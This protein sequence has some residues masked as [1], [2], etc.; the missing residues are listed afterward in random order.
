MAAET[1]EDDYLS[2]APDGSEFGLETGGPDVDTEQAKEVPVS[3]AVRQAVRRLHEN[4][5]HRSPQRLARALLIAGAPPE[6]VIAAKQLKCAVCEE[7]RPPKARRPASLPGPREPGD[8][9][10]L[11]IF[12]VFD[13]VG[14]RFAVLHAVDAVTKF[15]MATLVE[16]KSTAEVVK[17]LKERWAPVFGMPRVLVSDQGRE[18][19]SI[20]LEAFAEES[21]IFLYRIGVQAPWQNGLCERT[22]GILK[23]LLSACTAAKSLMGKEEMSLGLG[24]SVT[25]YNMDVGDSGF[26]PM[27][28]AVGRQPLLPG[29][30]LR[31]NLA[32]NDSLEQP[33]YARLVAIRETTRMAMLRLHFSR[34][35]RR[36]EQ[37]RSRNPTIAAAPVVGD[38]V[39]YWREQKYNKRG[40]YNQ[41]RLLLRKWHGSALLVAF[42]GANCYVTSRG[43]LTK[44]A[45]EHVRPASAMEKLSTGEWESVLQEVVEAAERDQ[46]WEMVGPRLS[47]AAPEHG[48]DGPGLSEQPSLP[49]P[50]RGQPGDS[51]APGSS[52][53]EQAEPEQGD[54]SFSD[55]AGLSE[56]PSLPEPPRGPVLDNAVP[57]QRT[58][59]ETMARMREQRGQDL[60]PVSA[61][62]F[63][64]AASAS[65]PAASR[66][67]SVISEGSHRGLGVLPATSLSLSSGAEAAGA[68]GTK[69]AAEIDTEDLRTDEPG[70]GA[71]GIPFDALVLERDLVLAA[72]QAGTKGVHPLVQLQAQAALDRA[73]GDSFEARDHGSWDGRWPLPSRSQYEAFV[74]AGLRWPSSNDAYAVQAARKEYSWNQM[75][76]E[77]RKAFTEAAKEA[78][79]VWVR[80]DAVEV[81]SDEETAKVLATLRQRGEMHK[82]M[83][84]RFVFTDKNDGL[85]TETN[86]LG[87]RASARL[88][89]P[90]YKDLTALE[91]RKD[92]PTASR[93]SQHLLFTLAASNFKKGWRMGSADVKSAFLKG[94]R[95]M[96]GVRELY[97]Q[98][99][100]SRGGSPTLPV[101]RRL[102]RIVK[103]VFGLSDA[104][105]EWFLRLRKSLTKET[106]VASTMDAA[107]FFLWSKGPEPQLEGVLCCHVDDLL[108]SGSSLAWASIER[109]GS[110]L[111]FGSIEKGSFVYCGKRVD[112]DP[113]SGGRPFDEGLSRELGANSC[114]EWAPS[115]HGGGPH[116]G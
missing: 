10:A 77:Q 70:A 64:R 6:A 36:A 95:Y 21:G 67:P 107:T 65:T 106:W 28:A 24:E 37:A 20:E 52:A 94:E 78:W 14:T 72:A 47:E 105:R 113:V 84:P 112:Q 58:L 51:L 110:E 43:T 66:R 9:I 73:S 79:D 33:T 48:E 103:G 1:E 62:E 23:S 32:E 59:R 13:A 74:K 85:R 56:K 8:Q 90:G 2:V 25:A 82:V 88:V 38:L 40:S 34:S 116:P 42:E 53:A 12:D 60:P 4:T 30:A 87:I 31:N 45:L 19:I 55:G 80:N 98:N 86:R 111:G 76:E 27:Q 63:V 104:P 61:N 83:T 69:R 71:E 44:V 54:A 18:F 26:S 15:Q 68:T 108:F 35:L 93:T 11:D 57:F 7:R 16:Q 114:G 102:S 92:A 101:G 81:L 50:P 3:A 96:D 89:V 22:G 75:N 5:G 97:L 99:V 49:E 100:E 91:L 41:R 115:R 39:Y 46:E 109:L 29:D 17:F